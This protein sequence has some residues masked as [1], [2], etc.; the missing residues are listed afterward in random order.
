[1]TKIS[2]FTKPWTI[3]LADLGEKVAGLGFDGVELPVRH[4][5]QVTPD[6]L[7]ELDQAVASLKTFG[8]SV[9]SIA[10]QP[11]REM[12][13]ACG[14]AG[15]PIIRIC[16]GIDLS[17]GY[18]ASVEKWRRTFDAILP[19]L[20]RTGVRIGVQ[21]HYGLFVASAVGLR[22]LLEPYDPEHVCAVLDA[23]H[24]AVDGEPVEMAVDIV[25]DRLNGLVNL[26]AAC[27]L[28]VSG[29]EEEA[30]YAVHWTTH[31]HGGYVW[32]DLVAALK[33]TGFDGVFCM[34]AEYSRPPDEQQYMGDTILDFLRKDLAHLESL[35]A[36]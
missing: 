30:R 1:L 31:D 3:P 9:D 35:L 33:R 17:I 20:E 5:Y 21:N 26:K 19:D 10:G 29:P 14:N 36:A 28:R 27:H 32:S 34:P 11:T 16:C 18:A 12:I 23:A 13:E 25:K 8:L 7:G 2:V 6:R 4:G 24:C 22:Q 15:V